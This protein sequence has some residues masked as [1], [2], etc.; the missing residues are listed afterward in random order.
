MSGFQWDKIT[1]FFFSPPLLQLLSFFGLLFFFTAKKT[2]KSRGRKV[3]KQRF[4]LALMKWMSSRFKWQNNV[5]ILQKKKS[6][7]GVT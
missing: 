2:G 4:V 5:F 1:L 7:R 3:Q 6:L